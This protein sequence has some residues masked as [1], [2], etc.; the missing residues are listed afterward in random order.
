MAAY[1]VEVPSGSV[2]TATT[3][4]TDDI[5]NATIAMIAH[6]TSEG[7]TFDVPS[8]PGVALLLEYADGSNPTV[9]HVMVESTTDPTTDVESFDWGY[10]APSDDGATYLSQILTVVAQ[11][12]GGSPTTPTSNELADAIEGIARYLKIP[13]D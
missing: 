8:D 3:K 12:E 4:I 1:F 11:R 13:I 6:L 2:A 7:I 9:P 10:S 5:T